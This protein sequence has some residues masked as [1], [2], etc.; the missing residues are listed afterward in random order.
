MRKRR[1]A[2]STEYVLV[3]ACVVI[4]LALWVPTLIHMTGQY[5]HRIVSVIVLPFGVI[6]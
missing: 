5:C 6:F 4:P 3:L 1:G 2:I